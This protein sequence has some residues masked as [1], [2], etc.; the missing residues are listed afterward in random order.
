MEKEKKELINAF[1]ILTPSKSG[2]T[3][4]ISR[5]K[6]MIFMYEKEYTGQNANKVTRNDKDAAKKNEVSYSNTKQKIK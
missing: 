4:E 3:I 2:D 6:K 1:R 5:L